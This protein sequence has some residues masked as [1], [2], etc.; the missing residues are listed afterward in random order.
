MIH[1]ISFFYRRS[2]VTAPVW[3]SVI[4]LGAHVAQIA[5][6]TGGTDTLATLTPCCHISVDGPKKKAILVC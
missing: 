6:R 2:H 1:V 5:Y 3:S 4:A